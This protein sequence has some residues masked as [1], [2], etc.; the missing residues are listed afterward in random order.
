M[1]RL[2]LNILIIFLLFIS[3][4]QLTDNEQRI[5]EA[6]INQCI[7]NITNSCG[8]LYNDSNLDIDYKN[9]RCI[10]Y[11][12]EFLYTKLQQTLKFYNI[13]SFDFSKI[14]PK[15]QENWNNQNE[16]YVIIH[17]DLINKYKNETTVNNTLNDLASNI[18][19]EIKHYSLHVATNCLRIPNILGKSNCIV[20]PL[21]YLLKTTFSYYSIIT[22]QDIADIILKFCTDDES[23]EEIG[24]WILKGIKNKIDQNKKLRRLNEEEDELY[25]MICSLFQS[26]C[27]LFWS[28]SFC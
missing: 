22:A 7:F 16:L 26:F 18:T 24:Y 27:G 6:E 20:M 3:S 21:Q 1:K 13:K 17:D 9:N 8:S 15:L 14:G 19:A 28:K 25:N 4:Y 5:I 10:G 23:Y 11:C 12:H 2:T